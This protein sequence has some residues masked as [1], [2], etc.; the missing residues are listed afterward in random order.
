MF[1]VI[2]KTSDCCDDALLPIAGMPLIGRQ[3]QWLKT[4]GCDRVAVELG[5]DEASERIDDWLAQHALGT[6]VEVVLGGRQLSA[7]QVASR[8][9]FPESAPLLVIPHDVIGSGDLARLFAQATE[10]GLV[11]HFDPPAGL[12]DLS[13]ARVRIVPGESTESC[14]QPTIAALAEASGRSSGE[15]APERHAPGWALVVRGLRDAFRLTMALMRNELPPV[16]DEHVWRP[17]IHAA[18]R[19]PGVWIARGARVSPYA[20]LRAPTFVGP[21][22]VVADDAVVGPCA[23]VESNAVVDRGVRLRLGLVTSSTIVGAGLS[24]DGVAVEPSALVDLATAERFPV[25]DEL[26]ASDRRSPSGDSS[27]LAR[28]CALLAALVL[29]PIA[30]PGWLFGGRRQKKPTRMA[31]VGGRLVRLSAGGSGW[32]PLDLWRRLIDVVR[33]VRVW[34]GVGETSVQ[35]PLAVSPRLFAAA[36][37]APHGVFVID[38]ELAPADADSSAK[39]RAVAWYAHAKSWRVDW[40]LVRRALLRRGG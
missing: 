8:A 7:R 29:A 38:S 24:L 26:I 1:A 14:D 15:H 33:G 5:G 11:A 19:E 13:R 18:E 12:G 40:A 27:S 36:L 37:A 34:V 32:K 17:A 20:T 30:L 2:K 4:I 9:G 10:Q 6:T 35:R 28:L 16:D 23:Q 22:A 39:V 3:L 31:L 25:D 21:G